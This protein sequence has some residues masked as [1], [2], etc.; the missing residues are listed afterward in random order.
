MYDIILP[1]CLFITL[2][3]FNFACIRPILLFKVMRVPL[4]IIITVKIKAIY[5]YLLTYLI[6][7][8]FSFSFITDVGVA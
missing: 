3:C 8:R 2:V 6:R 7:M 4:T 5:T 1:I